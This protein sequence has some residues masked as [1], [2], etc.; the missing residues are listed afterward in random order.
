MGV[1]CTSHSFEDMVLLQLA[2][3][4]HLPDE[5]VNTEYKAIKAIMHDVDLT[6]AKVLLQKFTEYDRNRD[7]RVSAGEFCCALGIPF[8]D[9]SIQLFQLFDADH[10]KNKFSF[11]IFLHSS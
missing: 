7:G 2:Q 11:P 6:K 3:K 4:K 10:G 5:T 1:P 9:F 8:N